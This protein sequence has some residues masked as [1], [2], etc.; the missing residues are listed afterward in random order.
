M[1]FVALESPDSYRV[2][3]QVNAELGQDADVEDEVR[4]HRETQDHNYYM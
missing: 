2:I 1:Y 3:N 4:G